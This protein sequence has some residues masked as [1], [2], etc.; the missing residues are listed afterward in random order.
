MGRVGSRCRAWL[1]LTV[2]LSRFSL[3]CSPTFATPPG[4]ATE[5]A[6]DYEA[7]FQKRLQQVPPGRR[8]LD[9]KMRG[10][11]AWSSAADS[12]EQTHQNKNSNA[13]KTRQQV[14]FDCVCVDPLNCSFFFLYR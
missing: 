3:R 12:A 6:S 5:G 14:V 2:L 11:L 4:G 1:A 13:P 7:A 8:G 9:K 10:L